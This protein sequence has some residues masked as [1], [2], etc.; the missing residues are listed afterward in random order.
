MDNE[1]L[2]KSEQTRSQI[3]QAAYHLFLGKGFHGASMREIAAEAGVALGSIYN[4][5]ANKEDI[6]EAVFIA[7]HPYNQ[8]VPVVKAAR[9]DNAEDLL[10]NIAGLMIEGLRS[11]TD[12]LNLMFI[13]VVE[14]QNRYTTRLLEI[15]LPYLEDIFHRVVQL[16]GTQIRPIPPLIL[17]RSLFGLFFSYHMT[18]IIL[19]SSSKVPAEFNENA[20]EHFLNIYLRG[21][22]LSGPAK[23]A[24]ID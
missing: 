12:F 24:D 13:D 17:A 16:G 22:L 15:Q 8:L 21:I 4:H 18:G 19:G 10:R 2:T 14:F 1:I 23:E 5:F 3:I 6:F 7:H 20:F 11:N 9:G